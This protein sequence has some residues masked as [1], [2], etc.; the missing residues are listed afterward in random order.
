MARFNW[1]KQNRINKSY[2]DFPNHYCRFCRQPLYSK[3]PI[4]NKCFRK[5]LYPKELWKKP[6]S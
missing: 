3:L 6:L 1:E 4:C 2:G 5:G